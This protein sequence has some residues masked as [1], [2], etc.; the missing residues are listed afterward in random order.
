MKTILYKDEIL[1]VNMLKEGMRTYIT[2][3]VKG[4]EQ[5]KLILPTHVIGL[6]NPNVT[7]I[8]FENSDMKIST[9]SES[10]TLF[11]IEKFIKETGIKKSMTLPKY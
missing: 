9:I 6:I 11:S 10:D 3:L 5:E 7:A 2:K 1:E 4:V 8:I